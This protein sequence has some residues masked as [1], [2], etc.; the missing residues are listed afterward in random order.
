[1]FPQSVRNVQIRKIKN[2]FYDKSK[3]SIHVSNP[4][5]LLHAGDK[6]S[7]KTTLI[8]KIQGNEDPK[9]GAGL[10]YHYIDVRDEYRDGKQRRQR[11]RYASL[12]RVLFRVASP[13][14]SFFFRP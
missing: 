2:Y 11:D 1:M 5:L 7:G 14:R 4:F 3:S 13:R 6:E 8:A 12:D 10:E 9:K